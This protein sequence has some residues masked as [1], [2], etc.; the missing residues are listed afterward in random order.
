MYMY[1]Y[2]YYKMYYMAMTIKNNRRNDTLKREK[3]T[4]VGHYHSNKRRSI[5]DK[6]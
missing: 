2:V 6:R 5:R 1:M 4:K 3:E